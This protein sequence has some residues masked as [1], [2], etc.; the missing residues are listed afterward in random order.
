M[1][2]L[3]AFCLLLCAPSS[4]A[5][6]PW[7]EGVSEEDKEAAR[8]ALAEGN[9]WLRRGLVGPALNRYDAAL[10]R[11]DHPQL[12]LMRGRALSL[13]SRPVE[14][15]GALW[16][17]RRHGGY[18][19]DTVS[20]DLGARLERSIVANAVAFLVVDHDG[21]GAVNLNGKS[22]VYGVGRWSGFV[23]QRRLMLDVAGRG[24]VWLDPKPGRRVHVVIPR[25]GEPVVSE[26]ELTGDDVEGYTQT[27]PRSPLPV[28]LDRLPDPPP[29]T[30]SLARVDA[31]LVPP[32]RD[33]AVAE[34]CR[35]ARGRMRDLCERHEH[36]VAELDQRIAIA[37][38]NLSEAARR[39]AEMTRGGMVETL[40]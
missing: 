27:L 34:A 36:E 38:K 4:G 29:S 12:H 7:H 25:V 9:E 35:R 32:T 14:A 30:A 40:E 33:E 39:N 28:D 17:A 20:A 21:A 16:E 15:L 19:L 6:P 2:C 5:A 3:L 22:V 26:R 18:G 11:W 8:R 37:M 10:G 1:R 23:E 31:L 13:L 24:P